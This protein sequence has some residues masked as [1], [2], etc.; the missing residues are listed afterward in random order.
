MSGLCHGINGLIWLVES[1]AKATKKR[2]EVQKELTEANVVVDFEWGQAETK[3]KA[4]VVEKATSEAQTQV[5][6]M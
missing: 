3:V 5:V 2:V 6:E 4:L 1:K